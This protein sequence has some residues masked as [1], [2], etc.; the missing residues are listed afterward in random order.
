[1]G[2][3]RA[4]VTFAILFA[5]LAFYAR[6]RFPDSATNHGLKTVVGLGV[7]LIHVTVSYNRY[8]L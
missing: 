8:R 5:L 6:P 3:I 4:A 7:K 1:M 2:F